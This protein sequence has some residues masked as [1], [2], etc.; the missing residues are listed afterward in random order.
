MTRNQRLLWTALSVQLL[1]LL[2]GFVILYTCA[3]GGIPS[4]NH[5][6]TAFW[7]TIGIVRFMFLGMMFPLTLLVLLVM[8]ILLLCGST[9]KKVSFLSTVA[10]FLWGAFW[11]F[12]TYTICAPDPD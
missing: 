1:A 11:I 8:L 4:H 12:V 9:W 10:F 6:E 5:S 2:I 7:G 3:S